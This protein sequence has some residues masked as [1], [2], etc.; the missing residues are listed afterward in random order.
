M[1]GILRLTISEAASEA[2]E[3][4]V[5]GV[6]AVILFGLPA[7]KDALGHGAYDEHGVGQEAVRGIKAAAPDVI[8][9]SDVCLCEYTD[10]GHCG[11]V[12]DGRIDNDASL[13]FLPQTAVSHARAVADHLAPT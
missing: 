4:A 12:R 10:H 2:E 5:L 7:E 3:L 6:S 9:M 8:V 11:V 13:D 1:P